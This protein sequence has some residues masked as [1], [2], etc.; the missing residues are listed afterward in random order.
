MRFDSKI[1]AIEERSDLDTITMDE[2]H[3]IL[4]SYEMRT[5]QEDTSGKEAAFKASNQKK[6]NKPNPKT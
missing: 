2:L 5:E 3:G 6:T 1:F 4:T